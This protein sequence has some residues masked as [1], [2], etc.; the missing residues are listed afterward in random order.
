MTKNNV[1]EC[2]RDPSTQK[3]LE[4]SSTKPKKVSFDELYRQLT[5]EK[6]I[7]IPEYHAK[8][9]HHGL[10]RGDSLLF[11]GDVGTGKTITARAIADIL[12]RP[13][14]LIPPMGGDV[15][16]KLIGEYDVA[17][18]ILELERL[19]ATND[20][21]KIKNT[22][23]FSKNNF[24]V[25]DVLKGMLTGSVVVIDEINRFPQEI[26]NQ[27]LHIADTR[28]VVLPNFGEIKACDGFQLIGTANDKD[29]GIQPLSSALKRRFVRVP[30][31]HP[32][33]E[34]L[35]KIIKAGAPE[36]V[37]TLI[38]DIV[39]MDQI[40]QSEDSYA[41]KPSPAELIRYANYLTNFDVPYLDEDEID[42]S[43]FI[44][45]SSKDTEEMVRERL[46]EIYESESYKRKTSPP[47]K[48]I[49][50]D[51][52]L[53]YMTEYNELYRNYN[54]GKYTDQCKFY[55][56]KPEDENDIVM[57]IDEIN[58]LDD[59][60]K[61]K[62]NYKLKESPK[63]EVQKISYIDDKKFITCNLKNQGGCKTNMELDEMPEIFKNL[64]YTAMTCG[65][66][67]DEPSDHEKI[68]TDVSEQVKS[69]TISR[70]IKTD[71]FQSLVMD[72]FVNDHTEFKFIQFNDDEQINIKIDTSELGKG[73]VC[74]IGEMMK[75]KDTFFS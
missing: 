31:E 44:V 38:E 57:T 40:L 39:N 20:V 11:T 2:F 6:N 13:L 69:N 23:L 15:I 34:T 73:K 10:E 63:N 37:D 59:D 16:D 52:E 22:N 29:M 74:N 64:R 36:A 12:E 45:S 18:Q 5:E 56:N 30:F 47:P 3:C 25:G 4:C 21:D 53:D 24:F 51:M 9:I 7:F 50:D 46:S 42:D 19:K 41:T 62:I 43:A 49:T 65:A 26:Q 67:Y 60:I 27:L 48:K 61:T 28:K 33:S 17:K 8:V 66:H 72:G 35:T 71:E 1:T 75:L 14:I 70:K 55:S 32:D 58:E 54:M 68:I